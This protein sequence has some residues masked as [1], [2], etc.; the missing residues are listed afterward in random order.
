MTF[1]YGSLCSRAFSSAICAEE[2]EVLCPS[3]EGRIKEKGFVVQNRDEN[4]HSLFLLDLD[5][6]CD[7][8]ML[9]VS[10]YRLCGNF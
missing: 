10:V 1:P 3:P 9:T 6:L 8:E 4:I 7:Q 5:S 2:R